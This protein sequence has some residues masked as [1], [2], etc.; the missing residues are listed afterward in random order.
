MK[1]LQAIRSLCVLFFLGM[2]LTLVA[3]LTTPPSGGNQKSEVSQWIGLVKVSILYNS[4]DVTGNNG[5]SREGKIWGQLVPYGLNNFGFG[6]S[7]AAPWRAGANENTVFT[8]SHD[9]MVE[10]KPLKAGTYGLHMITRE[11]GQKWTIIFSYNSGAWGSYFYDEKEDALRVEVSPEE[12]AFTEWLTF[13]FDQ[14]GQ[15]EA[16]ATLQWENLKVPFTISVPNLN[17]LY[18]TQMRSELQTTPGF[19]WQSW[20]S[21]VNFCL[22]NNINLEEA[23]TWS[24]S[25]ISAPFIGQENFTTLQTKSNV[26]AAL[27]REDE[28]EKV[29]NQAIAHRSAGPLQIHQYGRQLLAAGKHEKALAVFET[30]AERNPDAW[31]IDL[32]LARAYSAQGNLKK[33]LKHAK[34]AQEKVPANDTVNAGSVAGMVDKL[35][36]GEAI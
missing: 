18:L 23:L 26:L 34:K 33:A 16:R 25:A 15:Q 22:Q 31:F 3:Q 32:G 29:M 14:R 17:D 8:V 28:A 19:N 27:G 4:P 10:G 13:E 11:K 36:K 21:A 9:V 35:A 7:T 24:E 30:N 1:H 6:S 5:Q 2:S 12:N 20:V